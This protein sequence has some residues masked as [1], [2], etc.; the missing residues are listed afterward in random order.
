MVDMSG[1]Q[2]RC[3]VSNSAGSVTS[4]AAT[5]TVTSAPIYTITVQTDGNG[6]AFASHASALSETEI[7]LTA[8]ENEGYTF[9]RWEV[10]AGTVTIQ[11]NNT[12]TM[13]AEN[14]TVK[15]ILSSIPSPA[16]H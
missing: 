9:V 4:T 7:T 2:Y 15:A 6:T 16:R 5:L 14:V 8:Q 3:V 12:F 10:T 13:P 1:H 11:E